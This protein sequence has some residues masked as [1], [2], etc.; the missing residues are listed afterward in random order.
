[1]DCIAD[2]VLSPWTDVM[3]QDMEQAIDVNVWGRT[4]SFAQAPLPTSILTQGEEVMASPI[5]LAGAVDGKEI[6]WKR[7]GISLFSTN[8]AQA[9]LF[10]WQANDSIIV[11]TSIQIEYDGMMRVDMVIM[12]Q[13]GA[14]PL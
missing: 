11:N 7:K 10:G 8:K 4:Y 3:V 9:T 14:S 2:Q 12:P 1:M 6:S 5:R 13:A